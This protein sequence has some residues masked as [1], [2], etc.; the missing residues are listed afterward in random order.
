MTG[1]DAHGRRDKDAV[2]VVEDARVVLRIPGGVAGL[3]H[4]GGISDIAGG[5]T[6]GGSAN[7]GG[8]FNIGRSSD[9]GGSSSIGGGFNIGGSFNIGGGFNIGGDFNIGRS[10]N[11]GGA[12][13]ARIQASQRNRRWD[14]STKLHARVGQRARAREARGNRERRRCPAASDEP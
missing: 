4:I 10:A 5:F 14:A 11:V 7:I 6:I 9:I 12:V 2:C 8:G 1:V 13:R 3:H